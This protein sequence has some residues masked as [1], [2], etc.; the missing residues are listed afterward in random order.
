MNIFTNL[1]V[2][3]KIGGGFATVGLILLIT[4]SLTI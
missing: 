2:G 1:K 4:V 3:M